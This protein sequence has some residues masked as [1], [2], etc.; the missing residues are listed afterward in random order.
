VIANTRG[1]SFVEPDAIV[2]NPAD[3]LDL[4]LLRDGTG[5]TVGAFFGA[6]PFGSGSQNAGAP[7][8]FEQ[9]LW[10]KPVVLS[11]Q[12]GAGTAIV[13]AYGAAAQIARRGGLTVEATNSHGTQFV[14]DLVTFRAE[15]REALQVFRPPAF[16]VVSGL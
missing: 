11:D 12:I 14:E 2:M 13:G 15:Q 5:G 1:S 6:G 9:S 10:S 16:T 3:W 7:G 8:L 4:R